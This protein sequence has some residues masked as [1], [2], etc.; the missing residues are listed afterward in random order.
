MSDDVTSIAKGADVTL[1]LE[2]YRMAEGLVEQR[3]PLRALRLL[4][5]AL[6]EE[7]DNVAVQQLA[8]RAYYLS[9]QLRRAEATLRRVIELDPCDAWATHALGR[10]LERAGRGAE[11]A[12]YLRLAAAMNPEPE[13]TAAA[14]RYAD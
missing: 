8:G 11:A 6:D 5:P 12:P 14:A 10:T 7:R 2:T 13:Y 3:E 4:E 1:T 9:L